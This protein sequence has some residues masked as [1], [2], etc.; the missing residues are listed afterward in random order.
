MSILDL[1][2][3]VRMRAILVGG[4]AGI[5][6]ALL[7]GAPTDV[8][9]NGYFTRMTPVRPQDYVFLILTAVLTGL[10]AASYAVPVRG[11]R[12]ATGKVTAAG[13]LG[14]LA[15]GC[16]V[17]NKLVLLLLGT[18][19]AFAFWAPLQPVIGIASVLLLAATLWL[20]V[21]AVRFG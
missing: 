12:V 4:L 21:H 1:T 8:I 7:I 15:V 10:V 20:R 13:L 2:P 16:P 6:T 5:G 19:G 17:C 3:T 18:S 11:C 14:F 9:P